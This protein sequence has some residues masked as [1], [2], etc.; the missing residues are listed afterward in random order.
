MRPS[1]GKENKNT[2]V[3]FKK[4]KTEEVDIGSGEMGPWGVGRKKKQKEK[5]APPLGGNC[6][7]NFQSFIKCHERHSNKKEKK[8]KERVTGQPRAEGMACSGENEGEIRCET[9]TSP[10]QTGKTGYKKQQISTTRN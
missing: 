10:A 9:I 4:K 2:R 1:R 5:P 6:S 3:V 7:R 8:G